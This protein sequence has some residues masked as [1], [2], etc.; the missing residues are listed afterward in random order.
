MCVCRSILVAIC[1]STLVMAQLDRAN[2]NGTVTD[3]SGASV[4]NA[5]VDVVSPTTGFKRQVETGDAGVY[6]ITG[7]LIGT[8]DL[9]ISH[10]GFKT[11]EQ[12]GIALSVGQTRTVNAQLEVGAALQRVEVQATVQAL[13]NANAELG[14]VVQ[15]RQVNDIP[16]NGRDWAV[17][18]ALAPGGINLGGGGQRDM[19]FVGR[20]IDDSNYTFDGLDATGVQEQSQ[21]VGVRLSLSLDAIAEFRV[22]SSVY[23]ADKG[24]SAGAQISVVTKAGTN[25]F[26]GGVFEF[27]RNDKV[28]ARSPFDGS[29][30]PPF[31]LNQFGGSVGG[32]IKKNRTFF[33]ADY[34]GL[35][36][37]LSTTIIGFVPNAAYRASVA[38]TS[39][40]L[41]PFL[42]SW[43]IGQTH[44]D[45]LTDIWTSVGVDSRREDS[46]MFRLDHNFTD[47]TSIFGRVSIDDAYLVAPL[48]TLGGRDNPLI[49]PSNM[50]IQLSHV[51]SPTIFN[52]VRGGFNRSAMH[53]WQY[54][55]SPLSTDNGEPGYVGVSVSGFDTPS[56]HSLDTEVGTTIDG[57]DDLSIIR[58]RHTIKI[59][60]GVERHRLNN[61]SEGVAAGALTY[62]TPDNFIHNVL[63]DYSFV[64]QLTLGGNRRTYIMPYVQDTFKVSSTLTLNL[65][66]RYEYYTV[67]H[68]VAGRI[69]VVTLA[70]G[71]FCP[72]GTPLYFPDRTDFMPRLGLAWVPGGPAGR[73]V[74]RAGF[75][76]YFSPNQMDDFSDGHESTGQ[77]FDV[78]SADVPNLSWPVSPSLLPAPSYS[79]KSWDQNRKDG[80]DEDWDLTVQRLLPH[81]FL[82]QIAYQ[83]SEGHRL[84][85]ATRVNRIDPLTGTRPLPDFGE[86]NQ[87]ANHGNANFH[88]LQMSLKRPLTSGW[89]WEAHYM[90][91]HAL[92][93]NGFGA[94]QY[95]HIENFACIK[96]SYSDSDIDV[97]HSLSANSV[98]ELPFG[99]GKHFLNSGG[100]AG[101]LL[102]GW[103]L[104]G[105]ATA[106]SGRPIDITVDRSSSD[107]PD[108]VTRNQRP[109]LVP[110]VSIY[111]A[112]QTIN[113][114]FN[115]LAFA[116]PAVGVWGNLGR[117]IGRG[118][119]Y[120]EIDTA[121]EKAT[122]I[123]ERLAVKFRV[124]AFNLLNH[125]TYGDP[126]SDI[127]SGSFGVITSV[128]NSSAT[129]IG[130]PRRIQFMLR[131]EF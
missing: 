12:K 17:L 86:F 96:C 59:G 119:G 103:E 97:R 58:G 1:F 61:S 8:Y 124:E 51:F 129:G 43:P 20:A 90:W 100:V 66:L 37:S 73:T 102:G 120:Y 92:S 14:S 70:C 49:R 39:P 42:D 85:S 126:A 35:R 110:G 94:G 46:G 31:R 108:G 64:G 10:E 54:G 114:W 29:T 27:L 79:P 28:D 63:D 118:P 62:S 105:V 72:K 34:E 88:S 55:T 107:L 24:G 104:S 6:S 116:V 78:S 23:T 50:V 84:F 44:L 3:T 122:S 16:V 40:V 47:R 68:E 75:G 112:H 125:P 52:E 13:E 7:L 99:P 25:A 45:S 56:T 30:V 113:N 95:P 77:R 57:Y 93:D 106:S 41:K 18:M 74:I 48:D 128:L 53:H 15:S 127:S 33:F 5:K 82:G 67:L 60:V 109:D 32:P 26:H 38:A 4:P 80:Y 91:A 98:Y 2:L 19:R 111:P 65:G 87:K 117:N 89:M 81:S 36:Q 71:G 76:M 83:G 131:L 22:S 11:F 115:P 9:T 69:A 123:N 121:L 101:K 130:T 21:K